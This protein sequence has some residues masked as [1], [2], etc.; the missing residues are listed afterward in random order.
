MISISVDKSLRYRVE[1]RLEGVLCA[2]VE[3]GELH[4]AL[5]EVEQKMRMLMGIAKG[6]TFT[7]FEKGPLSCK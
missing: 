5:T 6:K 1:Y 4:T 2:V 7:N 3:C